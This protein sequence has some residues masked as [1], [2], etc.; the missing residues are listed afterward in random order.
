ML[1]NFRDSSLVE[2]W[3]P[4][5]AN[6]AFHNKAIKLVM[7]EIKAEREPVSAQNHCTVLFHSCALSLLFYSTLRETAF[8][9]NEDKIVE[10]I[11]LSSP[12][13][14]AFV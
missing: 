10:R 5:D 3:T 2:I 1:W 4:S 9:L 7:T 14:V 12:S 13:A 6:K 8:I 11:E